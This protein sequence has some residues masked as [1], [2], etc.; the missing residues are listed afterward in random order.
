[1]EKL[2][3]RVIGQMEEGLGGSL[4]GGLH[5][6]T[7]ARI[8]PGTLTRALAVSARARGARIREGCPIASLTRQGDRVTGVILEG[9]ER[10]AAERVILA[11]GAWCAR[12]LPEIKVEVFPVR[13]QML[14]LDARRP[15]RRHVL[16]TPRVYLVYRRDGTVL[17]G[18][19]QEKAG[20]RK[21]VTP[22]AMLKLL[23]AA[24]VLDPALEEA[25]LAGSWSG[26]RPGSTDELPLIGPVGDGLW[27]ATGHFRNGILLAPLTA[28]LT[29]EWVMKGVTNR[30]LQPFSPLRTPAPAAP[31]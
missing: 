23:A 12:L 17:V 22:K 25:E 13:G 29:A 2:T 10:L 5:F 14:L 20:F 24:L 19:T 16:V 15:P 1:V 3:S 26:L 28:A 31:A 27:L 9:G 7:G 21:A 8:E 4:L 30:M 11:A 18:S 6:P